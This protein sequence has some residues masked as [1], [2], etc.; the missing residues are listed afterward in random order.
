MYLNQFKNEG[1]TTA[2]E[3]LNKYRENDTLLMKEYHNLI[4]VYE[5]QIRKQQLEEELKLL[6]NHDR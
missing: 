4:N 6:E 3:I 2:N 5:K 1:K